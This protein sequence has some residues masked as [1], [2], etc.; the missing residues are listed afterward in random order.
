MYTIEH[1]GKHMGT[2]RIAKV[3]GL[4]GEPVGKNMGTHRKIMGKLWENH[5]KDMGTCGTD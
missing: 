1:I 2:V 5:E 3:M 4:V